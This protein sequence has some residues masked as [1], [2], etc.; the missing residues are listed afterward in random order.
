[1]QQQIYNI[2]HSYCSFTTAATCFSNTWPH[3]GY[4]AGFKRRS[5]V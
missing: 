4:Q 1:M 5:N 3:S 2:Q